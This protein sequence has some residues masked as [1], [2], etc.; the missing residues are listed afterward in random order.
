M[1]KEELKLF[2]LPSNDS[3]FRVDSIKFFECYKKFFDQDMRFVNWL[4]SFKDETSKS[5]LWYKWQNP[6]SSYLGECSFNL[7]NSR[8]AIIL[9][10]NFLNGEGFECYEC[11][12]KDQECNKK[13]YESIETFLN[14][15]KDMDI[16]TL[17]KAWKNK[18]SHL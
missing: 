2:G 1:N 12:Y 9:V 13:K 8:A 10:E 11:K 5:G 16:A 15:N 3:I 4:L 7:N 17:R 6:L 14:T 18:N